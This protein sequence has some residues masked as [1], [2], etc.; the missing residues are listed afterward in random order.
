MMTRRRW[1]DSSC[2]LRRLWVAEWDLQWPLLELEL[3]IMLGLRMRMNGRVVCYR[4]LSS[5][6]HPRGRGRG[7]RGT[8]Q[9]AFSLAMVLADKGSRTK[10]N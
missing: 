9:D 3:K 6:G 1:L 7:R 10:D 5:V 2:E 8:V 4:R